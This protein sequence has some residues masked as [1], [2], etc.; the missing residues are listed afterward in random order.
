MVKVP[1]PNGRCLHMGA[2]ANLDAGIDQLEHLAG[3]FKKESARW[4][5][6]YGKGAL[7]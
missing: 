2:L 6:G 1:E 3:V 7:K 4:R 5:E